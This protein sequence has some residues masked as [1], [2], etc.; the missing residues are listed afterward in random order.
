M[1]RSKS[2]TPSAALLPTLDYPKPQKPPRAH[3]RRK[4]AKRRPARGRR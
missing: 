4:A 2:A 3:A 1:K